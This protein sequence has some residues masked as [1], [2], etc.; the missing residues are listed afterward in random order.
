MGDGELMTLQNHQ[1]LTE[2]IDDGS[3]LVLS[4]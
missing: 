2:Q 4:T 1:P 3:H